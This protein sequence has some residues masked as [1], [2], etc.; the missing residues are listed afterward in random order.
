MKGTVIRWTL[1][2]L[3]A[4]A[5]APFAS[6][7]K[8]PPPPVPEEQPIQTAT[9]VWYLG[10]IEGIDAKAGLFV[11]RVKGSGQTIQRRLGKEISNV[12]VSSSASAT[13]N[14]ERK[15]FLCARDCFF[16]QP[17][18]KAPTLADFRAGDEVRVIYLEQPGTF[19]AQKVMLETG[20][21][22]RKSSRP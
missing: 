4:G 21:P 18:R 11:I 5:L 7:A 17:G 13:G 15:R 9:E 19:L 10:V 12:Y 22:G 2:A 14:D 6:A 16:S 8:K 1:V 3:L 20:P